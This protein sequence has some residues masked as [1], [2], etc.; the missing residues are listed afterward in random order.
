VMSAEIIK[1]PT[2]GSNTDAQQTE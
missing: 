1:T 2:A